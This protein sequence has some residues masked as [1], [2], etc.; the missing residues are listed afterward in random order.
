[1]QGILDDKSNKFKIVMKNKE[2]H[3]PDLFSIFDLLSQI[4]HVPR[5]PLFDDTASSIP[6]SRPFDFGASL[7]YPFPQR[8]QGKFDGYDSP[9]LWRPK[10]PVFALES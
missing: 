3:R 9:F 5:F 4:N 8:L 1:M 6:V 2:Q 7:E 10:N